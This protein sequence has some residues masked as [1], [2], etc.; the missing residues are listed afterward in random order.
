MNCIACTHPLR[1]EIDAALVGGSSARDVAGRFAISKSA[2]SRHTKHLVE[3]IAQAQQMNHA[4]QIEHG[5]T[6]LQQIEAIKFEAHQ[7]MDVSKSSPDKK[8]A[9]MAMTK[10]LN[11]IELLAKVQGAISDG[12][13]IN[14]TVSPE[15]AKTRQAIVIA[16]EPYPDARAA[17]A[18]ALQSLPA[19][20]ARP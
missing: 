11:C 14:L 1:V 12:T 19:T 2:I 20:D 9:L 5:G 18:K 17:V 4:R 15:W 16:L 8:T 7:I 13:T 10:M 6:L 3:V